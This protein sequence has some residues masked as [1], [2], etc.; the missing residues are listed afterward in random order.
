[1]IALRRWIALCLALAMPAL[2]VCC[3]QTPAAPPPDTAAETTGAARLVTPD[4]TQRTLFTTDWTWTQKS[5]TEAVSV[6]WPANT[7]FA[8]LDSTKGLVY[9]IDY[10]TE[11]LFS[12]YR[13][14]VINLDCPE[15]ARINAEMQEL[16]QWAVSDGEFDFYYTVHGDLLSMITC[17]GYGYPG[18]DYQ[19]YHLNIKTGQLVS[20]KTLLKMAGIA[21]QD[22]TESLRRKI[23]G[24]YDC[25]DWIN[26][27]DFDTN[28]DNYDFLDQEK[29]QGINLIDYHVSAYRAKALGELQDIENL[30][31]YWSAQNRLIAVTELSG[32]GGASYYEV[33][34]DAALPDD[35]YSK[36]LSDIR[37]GWDILE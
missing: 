26:Y 2:F 30:R 19:I 33:L 35:T 23:I 31:L 24:F 14:P 17:Q 4:T 10:A 8:P 5:T 21:E 12:T 18:N 15:A 32:L 1:M 28:F 11:R 7:P 25:Y 3:A 20:N 34:M 16:H 37:G 36:H 13:F 6:P 27:D 9:G 22:L 29:L